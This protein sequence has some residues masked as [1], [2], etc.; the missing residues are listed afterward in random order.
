MYVNGIL[1]HVTEDVI[2]N[3]KATVIITHGIAEHSGRYQKMTE[4]LN[5]N[6]YN[7]IKYDL[8]GHGQSAGARGK[9]KHHLDMIRDLHELVSDAKKYNLPV[10]LLGHSLGGLI[11]HMYAVTYQDV[12]GIIVSGAITDFI[13]DVLPLRIFGPKLLGW[14]SVKTNF[15]DNKLSRIR[16]VEKAYIEDP[17]NLKRMYGSLIGNML[18]KGVRYLQ[19]NIKN[20][21]VSTLILHGDTDKI[22]PYYMAESMYQ[23]I[24][25]EDKKIILYPGSYH[26][27]Y[28]D[29]DQDKVFDDTVQWLDEHHKKDPISQ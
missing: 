21:H 4:V 28:N 18:V 29:L 22:V 7:V 11:V 13:K 19:K 25:T 10:Y 26:E 9:L 1:L 15:A 27:I 24:S 3:A 6:G 5:R 23:S 17:F 2:D 16:E 8:R 20:H 12:E 14:Y